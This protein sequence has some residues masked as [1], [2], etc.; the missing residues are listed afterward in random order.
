M[1]SGT[2]TPTTMSAARLF[3]RWFRRLPCERASFST[4]ALQEYLGPVY[5]YGTYSTISPAPTVGGSGTPLT[6]GNIAAFLDPGAT[7]G[8]QWD[9]APSNRPTGTDGFNYV[10]ENLVNNNIFQATGRLDYAISPK[11]SLFGRYSSE[12]GQAGPAADSLLF[13]LGIFHIGSGEHSRL[14]RAE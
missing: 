1:R 3:M 7:A 8:C 13:T 5:S 12:A 4:A 2:F 9:V 11:N 14:R 10:N 6:N